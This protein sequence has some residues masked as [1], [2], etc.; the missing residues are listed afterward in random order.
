[1]AVTLAESAKLSTN[2]LKTSV[3]EM[4][5]QDETILDQLQFEDINGNAYQYNEEGTLPGTAFRDVNAE[6]SE[7]TGTVNNKTESIKMFGG[8]ADVDRFIEQTRGN[9]TSQRATQQA[10]KVKSLRMNFQDNFINGD[11]SVNTLAYDGL[12]TRL[13]G[14]QVIS[15]GTDGAAINTDENTRHGFF[16]KLDELI[17]LVPGG[18][19]ALYTNASIKAKIRS[20]ARRV[21]GWDMQ[22]SEFGVPIETYN[23][24]RIVDIGTNAAGAAILPQTETQGISVNASSIYAVRYAAG[25]NDTGVLGLWNGG[26]MVDDLGLLQSKPVYRT[27]IELYASLAVFG[28]GAAR[29]TGVLNG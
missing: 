16:D 10:L 9:L 7:S 8:D 19:D 21:G 2:Q 1:M 20:A 23:G 28:K 3:I 5:L 22:R 15:M 14:G 26:V 4:F 27:R 29:L 25:E 24:V 12:K 6:Y 11:D 18:A 13:T 17:A